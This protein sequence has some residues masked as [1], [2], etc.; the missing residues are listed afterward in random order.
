[1]AGEGGW[2]QDAETQYKDSETR[3]GEA[4]TA[5]GQ[6]GLRFWEAWGM[7]LLPLFHH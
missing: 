2:G 5:G 6:L 3:H 7:A 1:V 4:G